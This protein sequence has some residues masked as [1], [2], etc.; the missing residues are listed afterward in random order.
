MR[1]L[2]V[3][4]TIAIFTSVSWAEDPDSKWLAKAE[5]LEKKGDL[6]G[7][8]AVYR[9][10]LS[11][12]PLSDD[13]FNGARRLMFKLE[14]Y[15][16]LI[17]MLE[18]LKTNYPSGSVP[19]NLR[20]D[21]GM[22]LY[23]KGRRDGA[24]EE[25]NAALL[26]GKISPLTYRM[27]AGT[28][29]SVGDLGS[30]AEVYLM[31][32]RN[33]SDET[34]FSFEL[35]NV[36]TYSMNF[37]GASREYILYLEDHPDNYPVVE[38]ILSNFPKDE[39]T[40]SKVL[41]VLE[42]A[43]G[44]GPGD[45]PRRLLLSSYYLDI[46]SPDKAFSTVRSGV[47][48]AQMIAEF[49]DQCR[50]KGYPR[51]EMSAHRELAA[52]F[53]GSPHAFTSLLR[54]ADIQTEM[55]LYEEAILSY[56]KVAEM[57]PFSRQ[58][59]ESLL[60]IGRI[61]LDFLHDPDGALEVFRGLLADPAAGYLKYK[62][63]LGIG[64]C[65]VASGKLD[66]AMGVYRRIERTVEGG[67]AL[68]RMAEIDYFR[69]DFESAL[70]K[71]EAVS[72]RNPSEEY[73]NDALSLML[74]IEENFTSELEGLRTFASAQLKSRQWNYDEAKSLLESIPEDSP[75]ADDA[76]FELGRL[77]S[78]MSGYGESIEAYARLISDYP[79]S[80][81]S[82]GAQIAMARVYMLGLVSVEDAARQYEAFLE[83]YPDHIMAVEARQKL[84]EIRG[85]L[86]EG[87]GL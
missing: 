1:L 68:F 59:A 61:K 57:R 86:S 22:A 49:A 80:P 24:E 56:E 29:L 50:S 62:S 77:M 83:R 34:V 19:L 13:A 2:I 47:V 30:A 70:S 40:I 63:E 25:W 31:A 67:A 43:V 15:D 11:E 38:R 3:F 79:S 5:F 36:Y 35:A 14:R 52:R 54:M 71:L 17:E 51:F 26:Q 87:E 74:F 27:V 33:L 81:L 84:R 60:Q 69:G 4:I 75:L 21:L 85:A 58:K 44:G 82:P 8:L 6:E 65:L 55:G 48:S 12:D 32:R 37:E 45:V 9:Q 53:P 72:R 10:M 64:D 16:D 39:V 20:L 42:G 41:P 18:T 23:R 76:L 46:G 66:N 73:V 28:Y 78:D 7:A